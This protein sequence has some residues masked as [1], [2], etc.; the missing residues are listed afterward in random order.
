VPVLLVRT[1]VLV[2]EAVLL[3]AVEVC[4]IASETAAAADKRETTVFRRT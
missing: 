3:G 1:G 2:V 4:A